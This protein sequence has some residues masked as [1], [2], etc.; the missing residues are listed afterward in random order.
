LNRGCQARKE[1][2]KT[3]VHIP[4]AIY[5]AVSLR[6]M[7]AIDFGWLVEHRFRFHHYR[8][9]GHGATSI[10]VPTSDGSTG[11]V[12]TPV[13]QDEG[14]AEFVY[15]CWP[16]AEED[17]MVPHYSTSIEGATALCFSPDG[18]KLL[19][20]WERGSWAT[21]GG[22]VNA[23]ESKIETLT[24]E[25]REE[26]GVEVDLSQ[27]I[28]YLGGWSAG[29]ARDNLSND[30]FSSFAVRL[31]SDEFSVDNKE[32]REA[33]WFV[34]RPILDEWVAQGSK[35]DKKVKSLDLGKPKGD[36]AITKGDNGERN[37]LSGNVLKGLQILADGHGLKLN[38]KE[39]MQGGL[40]A[41][42]ATWGS[43]G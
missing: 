28:F 22:A 30:N 20:V 4:S 32:I 19:L 16:G 15:Y 43:L 12:S 8:A 31:K 6:A 25:L 9:P 11:A 26:V 36:P 38:Y 14:T 13:I 1:D 42:K 37:V 7:Q 23:G 24:R 10:A 21:P 40:K 29:R 17:D 3:K 2:P 33:E 5:V 27:D 41:V 34:W 35:K 18:S 39:E